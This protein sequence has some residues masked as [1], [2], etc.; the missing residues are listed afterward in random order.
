M[1]SKYCGLMPMVVAQISL[2][3]RWRSENEH[4]RNIWIQPFRQR[5]KAVTPT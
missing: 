2:A 1:R 3:S 5:A 4:G